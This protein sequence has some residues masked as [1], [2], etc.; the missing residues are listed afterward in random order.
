MFKV[1]TCPL[2]RCVEGNVY[3]QRMGATRMYLIVENYK[4]DVVRMFST[5]YL[6]FILFIF[7]S[8]LKTIFGFYIHVHKVMY[9]ERV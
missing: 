8:F 7:T 1:N 2:H 4:L 9:Q 5:L 3:M 6:S